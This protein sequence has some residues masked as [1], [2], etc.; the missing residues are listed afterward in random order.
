MLQAARA[1][2]ATAQLGEGLEMDVIAAVFLTIDRKTSGL[3]SDGVDPQ[4]RGSGDRVSSSYSWSSSSSIGDVMWSRFCGRVF[5]CVE[6]FVPKGLNEG[7]Q[8]IYCL[9]H[10]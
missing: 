4:S 8:A 10:K 9:G 5:A 3:S 1:M 6:L 7:S 2:A